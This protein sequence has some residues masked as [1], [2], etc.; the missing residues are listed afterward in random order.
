MNF[1]WTLTAGNLL[2]FVA[3]LAV[4][5]LGFWKFIY[6]HHKHLEERLMAYVDKCVGEVRD[7]VRE[8]RHYLLTRPEGLN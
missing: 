6:N 8:L 5:A 3:S 7:E 1:D 2:S 4:G